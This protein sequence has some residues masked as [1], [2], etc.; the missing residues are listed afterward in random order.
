M[1]GK[2]I[3]VGRFLNRGKVV[4]VAADHGSYMGP[5][6]GI[7]EL[8]RQIHAFKKADGVLIMPGMA[9]LCRDFFSKKDSPLCIIRVNYAFHYV[10]AYQYRRGY[11]KRLISVKQALSMGADIVMASLL[12]SG[13]EQADSEN[14]TQFGQYVEEANELGMPLIGEYIP[15]GSIDRFKKEDINKLELGTRAL[16]EFGADMMKTVYVENFGKIVKCAGIP[17]FALGGAKT[18]RPIDSFITA[19]KAVSEG[20]AGIVFGRN[21]ICAENP[22][23]YLDVLIEV[24][25]GKITAEE[26]EQCYLKNIN[27]KTLLREQDVIRL[28][29]KRM[30]KENTKGIKS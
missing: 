18:D 13:D 19:K 20:A 21:V 14:V 7:E 26:A 3:R 12:F 2:E 1:T 5:F 30:P 25:K 24:V 16:A 10:K 15:M 9:F 27:S 29:S 22:E 17:V 6:E 11:N 28:D 4:I 23:I 8:P